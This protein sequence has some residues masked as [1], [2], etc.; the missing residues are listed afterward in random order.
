M[1]P[2]VWATTCARVWNEGAPVLNVY[3][4]LDGE[5]Q[6]VCGGDEHDSPEAAVRIHASHAFDR[7]SNLAEVLGLRSGERASRSAA[8]E[9]WDVE[10]IEQFGHADDLQPLCFA[11]GNSGPLRIDHNEPTTSAQADLIGN[12]DLLCAYCSTD[13]NARTSEQWI[14]AVVSQLRDGTAPPER[15]RTKCKIVVPVDRSDLPAGWPAGIDA[16]V[17]WGQR[18]DETS[19]RVCSV[20]FAARDIGLSD[21]VELKPVELPG[22][23]VDEHASH[24]YFMCGGRVGRG[25]RA[26]LRCTFL[27]APPLDLVRLLHELQYAAAC[28]REVAAGVSVLDVPNDSEMLR[29]DPPPSSDDV[30][31]EILS[32][33]D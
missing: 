1:T 21:L 26:V 18:V 14:A 8:N 10:P 33:A 4:E 11:C 17:L 19:A 24:F 12:V 22:D 2:E 27:S 30:L 9:P 25:G 23:L 7:F 6:F 13:R 28:A 32:S 20:P 3:H 15:D 29:D 16:E 5:W 31:L